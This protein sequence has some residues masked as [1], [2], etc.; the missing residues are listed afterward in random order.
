MKQIIIRPVITEKSMSK[1]AEGKYAFEVDVTANKIEVKN[2][3]KQIYKVEATS[4]N[5]ANVKG[6]DRK[7]RGQVK[8]KTKETRKAIVTLKKGQ[9]IPGF[10]VK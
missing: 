3:I 6:K 9:K 2:A 10:E 4:V 1:T 8:G 7:W 5:I